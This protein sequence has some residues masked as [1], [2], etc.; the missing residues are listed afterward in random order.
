MAQAKPSDRESGEHNILEEHA[1]RDRPDLVVH[2][3]RGFEAASDEEIKTV[4]AFL[5]EMSRKVEPRDR[6]HIIW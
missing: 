3:S 4:E 2:D 1:W 5:S 6:L